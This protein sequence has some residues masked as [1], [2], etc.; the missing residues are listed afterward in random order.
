MAFLGLILG[1]TVGI[2]GGVYG[3]EKVKPAFDLIFHHG[4]KHYKDKVL[5]QSSDEVW[6]LQAVVADDAATAAAA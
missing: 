4:H 6:V 1:F 2:F 3:E 5:V